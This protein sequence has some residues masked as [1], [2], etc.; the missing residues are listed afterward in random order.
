MK[1]ARFLFLNDVFEHMAIL[2]PLRPVKVAPH[3][4][5][6]FRVSWVESVVVNVLRIVRIVR[7]HLRKKKRKKSSS[8]LNY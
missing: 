7:V 4:L 3:T 6:E 8:N 2:L 1:I 5:L